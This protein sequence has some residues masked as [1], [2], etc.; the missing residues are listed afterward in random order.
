[1]TRADSL[2]LLVRSLSKSEKRIF[3]MGKKETDYIVLF[4]IIDKSEVISSQE[5]KSEYE[6]KRDGGGFNVAATYLYK[7]LLDT[8]LSL[9]ESRDSH[10]MLFDRIMKA[11]ILFEKS[12]FADALDVLDKAKKEAV[13]Y[14]NHVAL[15]YASRMELEYLLY[16]DMPHISETELVNKH[17]AI[18]ETLKNLHATC[19]QSSLYELL[20]H[21]IIHK[22]KIR[23]QKQKDRMNDLVFA[24]MSLTASSKN[25]FN[26][27]KLHLLFQSNFLMN[28]GDQESASQSLHELNTLF[29][30]NPQFWE[31]PPF[32]YV[33]VLE[34]ILGNL[35]NM[36]KYDQMPYFI[37]RL[38]GINHPSVR[39]QTHV[40]ALVS[41]Y[42]LLPLLDRGDFSAC[43]K[44]LGREGHPGLHKTDQL[45]LLLQSEISLY[46]ALTYIGLQDYAKARKT[47]ANQIILDNNIY[48]YPIY[49]TIRITNLIVYYEM[50][51]LEYVRMESRSLKR[52][53]LKSGKAY[54]VE[55][56]MLD[57]MNKGTFR[58]ISRDKREKLWLKIEPELAE[59]RSNL[60]ERQLLKSFDFT[61]WIE[62]KVCRK[63]LPEVLRKNLSSFSYPGTSF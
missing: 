41:L 49:R 23:S 1:M 30:N 43:K 29:E 63:P 36:R 58:L 24:E 5:L 37:E 22:G 42:Q 50:D 56:L 55:L 45:T 28:I 61:A 46:T 10:Y 4:D 33:S 44:L 19:E 32:Y 6:K 25:S 21:R 34:G 38:S 51:D 7:I 31:N 18:S 17:F 20:R 27:R 39:F 59:I 16:L 2:I 40:E 52:E 54:R 9:R 47:L 53:I 15:L 11:R 35:R 13:R 26:A 57:L 62:S 12:L 14:E 8:L 60:F 48:T 3:R